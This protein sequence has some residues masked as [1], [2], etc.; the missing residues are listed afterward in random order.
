MKKTIH[1]EP[2]CGGITSIVTIVLY[3]MVFSI[4]IDSRVWVANAFVSVI[5]TAYLIFS[6][7]SELY[8]IWG[9]RIIINSGSVVQL[10]IKR[11]WCTSI[12]RALNLTLVPITALVMTL[13]HIKGWPEVYLLVMYGV[14][15]A[16]VLF[17]SALILSSFR[18]KRVARKDIRRLVD[19]SSRNYAS[20]AGRKRKITIPF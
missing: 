9:R 16:Y 18:V 8:L 11:Q 2:Y 12:L 10:G 3:C 19:A 7:S 1:L 15:L 6:F 17:V 5:V 20:L 14:P 13:T 4:A